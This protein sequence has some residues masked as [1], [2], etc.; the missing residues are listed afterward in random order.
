MGLERKTSR[1]KLDKNKGQVLQLAIEEEPLGDQD[2]KVD[3]FEEDSHKKQVDAPLGN[4]VNILCDVE[5]PYEEEDTS[6]HDESA[7]NRSV[8]MFF[9]PAER[10]ILLP[11]NF[12]DVSIGSGFD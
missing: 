12:P 3:I 10:L 4:T 8:D 9:M 7:S 2:S 5:C 6:K 11:D 1:V